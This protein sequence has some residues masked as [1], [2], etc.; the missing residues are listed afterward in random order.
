M[1]QFFLK[2]LPDNFM[3]M[4]A[5]FFSGGQAT[6]RASHILPIKHQLLLLVSLVI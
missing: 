6:E 4:I 5:T 1:K 2:L 3:Q